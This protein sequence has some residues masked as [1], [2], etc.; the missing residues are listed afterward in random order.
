MGSKQ[1][2]RSNTN[3]V[4]AGV[5]GG[6]AEYF[7][8]DP[9]VLR[10]LFVLFTFFGGSGV[11]LYIVMWIIMPSGETKVLSKEGLSNTVVEM[12]SRA[13]EIVQ[14]FNST[15]KSKDKK[16]LSIFLVA[17][18]AMFLVRNLG[19][20]DLFNIDKMWPLILILIGLALLYKKR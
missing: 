6:L 7:E 17:L 4:I 19:F 18:G 13:T 9:A 2:H 11:L 20:F 3:R 5:C 10:I 15:D 12:K 1:L 14:G 8:I 16:W